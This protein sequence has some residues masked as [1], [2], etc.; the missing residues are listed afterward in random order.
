MAFC[1]IGQP[2]PGLQETPPT[3][4]PCLDTNL[5]RQRDKLVGIPPLP[6]DAPISTNDGLGFCGRRTSIHAIRAPRPRVLQNVPTVL[7]V[8]GSGDGVPD[9]GSAQVTG[10]T[11]SSR[12]RKQ[13]GNHRA[14]GNVRPRRG[15]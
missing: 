8:S 5:R 1:W 14:Q 9:T 4:R 11:A 13:S 12:G 6:G 10:R 3:Q 7:Q 2:R 15:R